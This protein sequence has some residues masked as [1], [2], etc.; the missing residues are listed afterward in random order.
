V[1]IEMLDDALRASEADVARLQAK[2][3]DAHTRQNA[4]QTRLESANNRAR[5]RDMMSGAKVE[6]A[7]SRFDLL[8]RR[9]DLAEGRAEALALAAPQTLDEQIAE[10]R[11]QE[12]VEAELE[13]LKAR[14]DAGRE[15]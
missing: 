12:R 5:M 10:L 6:E 13:L 7:F 3:R 15:G 1:E 4:I 2:L 9:A 11:S 14:L 8:E